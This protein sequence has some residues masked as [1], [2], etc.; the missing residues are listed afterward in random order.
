MTDDEKYK[1]ILQKSKML[2]RNKI[3][4]KKRMGFKLLK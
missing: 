3:R 1:H 2:L 4:G